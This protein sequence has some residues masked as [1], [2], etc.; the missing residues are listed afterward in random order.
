MTQPTLCSAPYRPEDDELSFIKRLSKGEVT[1]IDPE[2]LCWHC[3][4]PVKSNNQPCMLPVSHD[5]TKNE[6][7]AMG[8]FCCPSCALGY[9]V[10]RSMYNIQQN[11]MWMRRLVRKWGGQSN[12]D[13]QPAL[14]SRFLRKFGGP[15]NLGDF[16][17]ATSNTSVSWCDL[18]PPLIMVT[19][20]VQ[21]LNNRRARKKVPAPDGDSSYIAPAEVDEPCET[22]SN[23]E[24]PAACVPPTIETRGLYHELKDKLTLSTPGKP[25]KQSTIS[26]TDETQAEQE[27]GGD[28]CEAP[29]HPLPIK[30]PLPLKRAKI[31]T[32]KR[33]T[34][35]TAQSEGPPKLSNS[36]ASLIKD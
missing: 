26:H 2:A 9:A 5:A 13:F 8:T 4:E 22:Q 16:R 17:A 21:G 32:K 11:I 28:G 12:I 25:E 33:K 36:L 23:V 29:N 34:S 3:V 6:Y 27:S 30:R 7:H 1:R 15:L 35:A 20:A 31:T 19:D 14:P 10:E 18:R 24:F